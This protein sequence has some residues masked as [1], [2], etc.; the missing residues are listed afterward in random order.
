MV[1][2]QTSISI[3]IV[4]V[5]R[6]FRLQLQ[7]S[8]QEQLSLLAKAKVMC[9]ESWKMVIGHFMVALILAAAER[10]PDRCRSR[11]RVLVGDMWKS[12]LI[13]WHT[14]RTSVHSVLMIPGTGRSGKC[15]Q[16]G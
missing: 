15:F 9:W 4:M 8:S 11:H 3:P 12:G 6:K 16:A 2:V 10:S 1:K 13:L 14:A 7:I 5:S